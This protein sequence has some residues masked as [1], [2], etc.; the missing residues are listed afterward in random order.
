M[1][2]LKDTVT[3]QKAGELDKW[4]IPMP[5][6]STTVKARL[7]VTLKL[8]D[9]DNQVIPEGYMLLDG[10]QTLSS[11]DTI[12]F[13]AY[14]YTFTVSPDSIK[15]INNTNGKPLFMKVSF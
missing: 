2:E 13:S 11:L 15:A 5:T 10:S 4:G 6:T 7:K 14:G 12:T 8:L 9:K 1:I 3:I